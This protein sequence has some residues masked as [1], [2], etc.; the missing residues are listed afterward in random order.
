MRRLTYKG[1]YNASPAW[2][3]LGDKIAY[4]SREDNLFNIF[5]MDATG[6]NIIRLTYRNGNNENPSW[7]PDGKHLIFSSTRAGAKALYIMDPDGKNAKRLNIPGN[8]QT[9]AWSPM[10]GN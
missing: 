4:V 7:S 8:V 6:D 5:T 2:S 3:P 10:P 9:P 1:K